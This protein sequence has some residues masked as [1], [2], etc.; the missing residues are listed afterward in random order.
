MRAALVLIYALA[1]AALYSGLLPLWEGFDEL[2]HYAYVQHLATTQRFPI[3]GE[4]RLS[5]E[6]WT[7]L[8]YLPVSHYIQP[9]LERPSIDFQR[10]FTMASE[11][12]STLRR[13][14]D[15]LDRGL[16]NE[17]SPRLTYEAMQAP[18]TYILLA[19]VDAALSGVSLTSRVL[20]L[21]LL[22]SLSAIALLWA[23]ALRL[24]RHLGLRGAMQTACLFTI[25]SCQM[26]YAETCRVGNDAFVPPWLLFLLVAVIES[27][28]SPTLHRSAWTALLM[29]AG[30][31]IK[32]SA[33]V[34]LPLAFISPFVLWFRGR[35][36]MSEAVKHLALSTGIIGLLAGPWYLRNLKLYHNLTATVESTGGVGAKGLFRAAVD[37]PWWQSLAQLTHSALWT[38]NNSFTT[39]SGATLNIVLSLLGLAI[40]LYCCRARYNPAEQIT[41][42]AIGLYATLIIAITLSFFSSSHGAV[43]AAMPWY[44]QVPL[45]PV[46]MLAFLG[47]GRQPVWGSWIAMITIALWA[48]VAAVS[49]LAKLVP[50]YGGFGGSHA[51]AG[52]LLRWYWG[53]AGERNLVLSTLCPAPAPI[54]YAL[55]A[56]V[57]G[58]LVVSSAGLIRA[59]YRRDTA[60]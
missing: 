46:L 36:Q 48:Y 17:P 40:I 60:P 10:Y 9:Y 30:L 15:S 1:S 58:S 18:L 14:A 26:L 38:G 51:R 50:L 52:Q 3:I 35:L 24:A 23:G 8:D 16:R 47:M 2:Y 19:P 34:F 27:L 56:L 12:R 59:I 29:V 31:L 33:L 44:L 49:W 11:Q 22:L 13:G 41:I 54:L 7:S 43:I 21:R 4:T 20:A 42:A 5:N 57:L 25:F 37:L 53:N 45:A 39:F 55:L 6:L 28:N 32:S